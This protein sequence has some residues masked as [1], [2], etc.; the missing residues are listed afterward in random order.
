[1]PLLYDEQSKTVNVCYRTIILEYWHICTEK[2]K[3]R[4]VKAKARFLRILL[5][6]YAVGLCL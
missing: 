4:L 2:K 6:I 3:T 5:G 1:M